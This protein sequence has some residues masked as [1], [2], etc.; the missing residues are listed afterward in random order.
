MWKIIYKLEECSLPPRQLLVFRLWLW[1]AARVAVPQC[2][3]KSGEA[4]IILFNFSWRLPARLVDTL[5]E[6]LCNQR[7]S[8]LMVR[9]VWKH[10]WGSCP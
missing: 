4:P 2:L 5:I 7:P 6:S 8:I 1:Q 3:K 10:Q 9:D